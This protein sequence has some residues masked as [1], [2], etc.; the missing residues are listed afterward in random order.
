[1]RF[2]RRARVI[3][4]A[5]REVVPLN[6]DRQYLALSY[7]W[8][9]SSSYPEQIDPR[10]ACQYTQLPA[11]LPQ[12]IEDAVEITTALGFQYLWIDRY[13]IQQFHAADKKHQISQMANIYSCGVASICALGPN[14]NTGVPGISQPLESPY[15]AESQGMKFMWAGRAIRY[16]LKQSAWTGRGW[17]FQE[18]VLSPRCTFFTTE[19]VVMACQTESFCESAMASVL[20]HAVDDNYHRESL[21]FEQYI[22]NM[23]GS[24]RH[25]FLVH[26]EAYSRR[27]L[28]YD[29]DALHAFNGIL[30][31]MDVPSY[32]GIPIFGLSARNLSKYRRT[33]AEMVHIS[34]AD[35]LRWGTR[36]TGCTKRRSDQLPSWSWVS[37][38]SEVSD[39]HGFGLKRNMLPYAKFWVVCADL[40]SVGLLEYLSQHGLRSNVPVQSKY[41]DVRFVTARWRLEEGEVDLEWLPESFRT[42]RPLATF[43]W[44]SHPQW[45]TS[46]RALAQ[47]RLDN[48]PPGARSEGVNA[49]K[50]CPKSGLAIL[51]SIFNEGPFGYWL[52]IREAGNGTFYREGLL[53]WPGLHTE[54][55]KVEHCTPPEE[56][57]RTIRLG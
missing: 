4:C 33:L 18:A 54:P 45:S 10:M 30:S 15:Q 55:I 43:T 34:F 20:S 14:D 38:A 19:G 9:P 36:G 16:F 37:Q 49:Y 12:T 57:L 24:G 53:S 40:V 32:W 1:M 48:L 11:A 42:K 31:R 8:G 44:V 29:E 3:D 56:S 26:R 23:S 13:C 51:L 17:T 46:A 35:G 50:D 2:P 39:P 22:T 41:L 6:Q 47:L 28:G 52:M 27:K 25:Q 5:W 21:L 7:V